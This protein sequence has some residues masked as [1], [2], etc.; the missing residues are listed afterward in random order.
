MNLMLRIWR[1]I[2]PLARH[3]PRLHLFFCSYEGNT[4]LRRVKKTRTK[5]IFGA[6]VG[7]LAILFVL[8]VSS[9]L[10]LRHSRARTSLRRNEKG[11]FPKG[12]ILVIPIQVLS[13]QFKNT[14]L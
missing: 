2:L 12:L 7:V 1:K 3:N 14:L 5:L 8:T 4:H 10:L 9:I 6:S 13:Y 11:L